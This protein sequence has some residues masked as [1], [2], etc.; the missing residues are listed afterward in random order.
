MKEKKKSDDQHL[1]QRS[2]CIRGKI[3]AGCSSFHKIY[4]NRV[5]LKLTKF[6]RRNSKCNRKVISRWA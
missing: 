2:C 3:C 4:S 1:G 6:M 5:E